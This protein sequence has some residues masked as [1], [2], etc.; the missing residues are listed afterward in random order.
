MKK[1]DLLIIA[2]LF[3]LWILWPTIDRE[4]IKKYFYPQS[5]VPVEDVVSNAAPDQVAAEVP[6]APGLDTA[7]AVVEA[8]AV[9]AQSETEKSEKVSKPAEPEKTGVI[10]NDKVRVVL[11][12][13]GA[14]VKSA[15]LMEYRRN[16]DPESG[17]VILNFDTAP[18]LA[19]RG[20]EGL[21]ENN[22]FSM[23]VDPATRTAVFER[24]TESGLR[25][26]RHITLGDHYQL[27]ITDELINETGDV[28]PLT[29][30]QVQ[31]GSMRN[32]DGQPKRGITFMGIDVLGRGG[33]KVKHWGKKIPKWFKDVAKEKNLP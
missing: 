27:K 10:E 12:S 21:G 28:I 6:E 31:T 14:T 23:T 3:G 15:E 7:E 13:Y 11:S 4:I 26:R 2:V 19:Y 16:I 17:P 25:F 9:A 22:S 30:Y 18:A 5:A 32:M 20:L 1:Q 8:P 24:K 29:K 33:D